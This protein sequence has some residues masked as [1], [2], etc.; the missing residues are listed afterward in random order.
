MENHTRAQAM[1]DMGFHEVLGLPARRGVAR[2]HVRV[3]GTD[4]EVEVERET[5][6]T[7]G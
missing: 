2:S 6:Y 1:S 3:E 4:S 7:Q 5:L